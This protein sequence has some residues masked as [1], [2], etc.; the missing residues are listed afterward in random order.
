MRSAAFFLLGIV[1]CQSLSSLPHWGVIPLLIV[2]CAMLLWR[3]PRARDVVF[4]L[5]GVTYLL[6]FSHYRLAAFLP[7][8]EEA[9]VR[10]VSGTVLD[11]ESVEKGRSRVIFLVDSG[12][13]AEHGM[14]RALRTR[15]SWR[16]PPEGL[17][18]GQRWQLEAKLY[19]PRHFRNP[20]G[21][22]YQ[23]WLYQRGIRAT[24]YVL[25]NSPMIRL[26][27]APNMAFWPARWRHAVVTHLGNRLREFEQYG[28]L[29]ALSVGE[30]KYMSDAQWRWLKDTGT[31]HLFA[32]SGLHI[33]LV[34]VLFGGL[35][36]LL[37]RCSSALQ[38]RLSR[39]HWWMLW[40][41]PA[42]FLYAGL[43]GFSLS[44]QRALWML[45]AGSMAVLFQRQLNLSSV[46]GVALWWVLLANPLAPMSA[47]FW[48][49]FSAVA[50]IFYTHW[51]WRQQ[52]RWWQ[53]IW[54]SS[55]LALCTLPMILW[56][57]GQASVLSPLTNALCIPL[58]SFFVLPVLMLALVCEWALPFL[59]DFL[60]ALADWGLS[61]M[62]AGLGVMSEQGEWHLL[63]LEPSTLLAGLACLGAMIL[64]SPLAWQERRLGAMMLL[65]L[66]L[67][68]WWPPTPSRLKVMVFDVGHGLSV[69]MQTPEGSVLYD[70]GARFGLRLDAGADLIAPYLRQQGIDRVH[71][72][73]LSHSDRDHVGGYPGLSKLFPIDRVVAGQPLSGQKPCTDVADWQLSGV[74]FSLWQWPEAKKSDNNASCVLLLR[75]GSSTVL[76]PGDIEAPAE[77]ALL[78]WGLPKID[79]LVA[80]HHGSA[81][82]S[83]E[84][85]I[86]TLGQPQVA[87][88]V[89]KP[90]RFRLPSPKVLERYR[91]NGLDWFH[92]GQD[93]ALWWV[94]EAG[95]L[96]G[97]RSYRQHHTK[98]WHSDG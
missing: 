34:A 33:G 83:S 90:S 22:D 66:G 3:F 81:S 87:I 11:V 48:L 29:M 43:A 36:L 39:R 86:R 84:A 65:A 94:E 20:G 93:G 95:Q 53:G 6:C 56:F 52:H 68:Q 13:Y 76:L 59:S 98:Y 92:T 38:V 40:A 71:T 50:W 67:A 5:F 15:L 31:S 54:V 19:R 97:P 85:F 8:P 82:S 91:K 23:A 58:V 4:F 63:K 7:L 60:W 61:L 80:P 1:S 21:F 28:A 69:L 75:T 64:L 74:K 57:F 16:S 9:E 49:S 18:I 70:T 2:L 78:E 46:V 77:Q 17:G 72:L 89:D 79:L 62:F 32:I 55:M 96:K 44:T 14:S 37:W 10:S 51:Q 45:F 26:S 25:Y 41:L 73:I 24:G 12:T 88:S 47:G 27:N 42:A 30:R 35:S